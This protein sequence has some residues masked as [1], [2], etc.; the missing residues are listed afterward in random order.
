MDS[1]HYRPSRDPML[2]LRQEMTLKNFSPHT[3]DSYTYYIQE[4]LKLAS[5][6]PTSILEVHIR[7]YLSTLQAKNRSASTINT[8][9]SALKFYFQK[10]LRR[11]FFVHIPRSKREKTLPTV[12]SKD[13]VKRLI[14]AT[15]NPKHHTI[16]SLLYGAGLR[17]SELVNLKMRDIDIARGLIHI[18]KGKGK[19]DRYTLFPVTLKSIFQKQS[20]L[21]QPSDFIFTREGTSKALTTHTIQKI[22]SHAAYKANI[23]KH[24]HPHTLR[25]SFATH[26]L[27]NGTDIRYIQELLGHTKIETTLLYTHV[28]IKNTSIVSPLDA[29]L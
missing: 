6:T 26:L 23:H 16:I 8:A 12:L 29:V 24:V 21:K 10:I 4:C 17:V 5:V 22:V 7:D 15:T 28:T 9:Y 13:E 14:S 11:K 20:L 25:H 1:P 27:E 3:I 18:V 2:L 19:K